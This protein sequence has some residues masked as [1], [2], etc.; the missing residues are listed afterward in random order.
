MTELT[1]YSKQGTRRHFS[2]LPERTWPLSSNPPAAR[3]W[4]PLQHILLNNQLTLVSRLCEAGFIPAG[5]Y[6]ITRWYQRE[7]TTKRFSY[8]FLGMMTSAAS[9]GLIAF[10][11]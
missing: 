6:T 4:F 2:S 11:M 9:S 3:V 8:Y 1:R 5:L 10:G 7:E